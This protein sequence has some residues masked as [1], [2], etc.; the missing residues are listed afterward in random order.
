MVGSWVAIRLIALYAVCTHIPP[1]RFG[2]IAT[3]SSRVASTS[4]SA[5]GTR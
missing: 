3:G 1:E 4:H 2:F 5:T